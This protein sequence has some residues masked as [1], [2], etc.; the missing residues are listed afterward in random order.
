MLRGTENLL[1]ICP[2]PD[3]GELGAGATVARLAERGCRVTIL[4]LS[5][6]GEKTWMDEAREAAACL[7]ESVKV[8]TLHLTPFHMATERHSLMRSLEEYRDKLKPDCVMAP[9]AGDEHQDHVAAMDEC[10]RVFKRHTLLGYEIVRS[11]KRFRPALFLPVYW[12]HVK[13]KCDALTKYATQKDKYYCSPGV[14][15]GLAMVRGA[16]C[17]VEFAEA[18]EVEWVVA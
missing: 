12:P 5:D 8:E 14:I 18:F 6:R 17:E 9:A 3:D 7:H 10:R 15:K 2:H 16:A 13:R 11:N 4:M 1:V